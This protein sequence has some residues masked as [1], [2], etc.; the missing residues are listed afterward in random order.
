MSV[1][2]EGKKV[3]D[4]RNNSTAFSSNPALCIRDFLTDTSFGLKISTAEI[5]DSASHHGG[6]AYAA[7]RCDDQINS[8]NRYSTNGIFDLSQSPKQILDQLLTSCSGK[9]IYQNGKFNLYVGFYNSPSITFTNE[10]FIEP[11]QL[12]TKLGRKDI[13]NR[14]AGTF[15]DSSNKFI[16]QEFDPIASSQYKTEDNA[17]EITAD[18]EFTMTTSATKA[19]ELA[20]IELLKARQQ[21]VMSCTT[22]LSKGMQVQCGDFVNV[23]NTRLGFSSKPFEVQEWNLTSSDVEGAPQLVCTMVL[24]ETDPTV[25]N[26]SILSN[27]NTSKEQA[28]DPNPDTNLSAANTVTAPSAITLSNLTGGEVEAFWTLTTNISQIQLEFKLSTDTTYT[29]QLMSGHNR[30]FTIRGL[31]AGQTYNF[32][33]KAINSIGTS[34]SYATANITL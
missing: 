19:R 13:F 16:V 24:R 1:E 22:S 23:T 30:R 21:I 29:E 14:V 12:V 33:V 2:I 28:T 31:T 26:N 8:A 4:P 34:S 32:R 25:Y 17:E 11:I 18:V 7:A 10:D 3:F 9:L 27:I 6:F 20:L 5:N 15:Y